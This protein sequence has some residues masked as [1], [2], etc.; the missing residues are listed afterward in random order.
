MIDFSGS[1]VITSLFVG[2]KGCALSDATARLFRLFVFGK[3]ATHVFDRTKTK[4]NNNRE[5]QHTGKQ[6]EQKKKERQQE[7]LERKEKC[8]QAGR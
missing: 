8:R 6:K 2:E 1:V 4:Q 3:I 5:G 7:K